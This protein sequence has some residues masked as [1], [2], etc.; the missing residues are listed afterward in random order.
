MRELVVSTRSFENRQQVTCIA[1][2]AQATAIAI[3]YN[4][5]LLYM[6]CLDKLCSAA[7]MS[8]DRRK[9]ALTAADQ[10]QQT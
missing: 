9:P 3:Q 8:G 10:R 6:R 2:M 5:P 7:D 4:D 1:A